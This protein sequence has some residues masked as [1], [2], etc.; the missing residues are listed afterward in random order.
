MSFMA[1]PYWALM[2]EA[3][4]AC[5]RQITPESEVTSC[6]ARILSACRRP[7]RVAVQRQREAAA[8]LPALVF[9][10]PTNRR[11]TMWLKE[12]WRRWMGQA[13]RRLRRRLQP[14][15]MGMRLTVEALEERTLPSNYTAATPS[16]LIAAIN[17]PT[18]LARQAR[19][20]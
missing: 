11:L 1:E 16:D 6:Q 2:M 18:L 7:H 5:H 15:R 17:M 19:S 9:P 3:V 8:L 12:L 4:A 20:R 14:S 10:Q 13:P